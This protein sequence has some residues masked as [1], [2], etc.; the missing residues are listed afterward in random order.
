M[1]TIRQSAKKDFFEWSGPAESGVD[2]GG[3]QIDLPIRYY[4]SDV[5]I[6]IFSAELDAARALLPSSRLQPVRLAK[7]R[8]AAGIVAFNYVE[9]GVGAYGEIGIAVLCTLDREA[10]PF[11]PLLAE[12]AWPGFGAFIAHL[13][14]TTRIARQAGRTV[15]GYPKFVADMAFDITPES[16]HVDLREGG[17]DILSFGVRRTG[18]VIPDRRALVTYTVRGNDLVRTKIPTLANYQTGFGRRAGSLTLG[19]HQVAKDLMDLGVG[20]T[21]VITKSYVS[22]SAILPVGEVVGTTDRAY[23]GYW[24]AERESGLHTVRYDRGTQTTVTQSTDATAT[25]T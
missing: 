8:A 6:G 23:E 13:P 12:A 21:P 24:G 14:V 5:F 17:S 11:A 10:P 4:R 25:L 22:H 9:T 18:L 16:Q 3:F 1:A 15:W 2:V 7:N 19:D 20:S